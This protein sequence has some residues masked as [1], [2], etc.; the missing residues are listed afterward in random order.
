MLKVAIVG[1]GLMGRHHLKTA[2]RLGATV[3]GVVD[4]DLRAAT[5][6]TRGLA[7]AHA[8]ESLDW[9]IANHSFDV[10]HVCT[11]ASSH[12]EIG[13]VL[14]KA[15]IAAFVEKPLA[16]TADE[17]RT[18]VEAFSSSGAL[19]CPV[20]QYAFQPAVDKAL[21]II[22][23]I[24]PIKSLSFDIVS[25]GGINSNDL[26]RTAAEILPHPLAILQRLRPAIKLEKLSWSVSRSDPGEWVV[27]AV[28][29]DLQIIISISLAS[30][31][32][33]F[34]TRLRGTHGSIE[35]NN[36]H[37][38]AVFIPGTVSR[39]AKIRQPFLLAGKHLATASGNLLMRAATFESAYPGLRTLT[40]KFYSAVLSG[41]RRAAPISDSDIIGLA[42]ARDIIMAAD[43]VR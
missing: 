2:Q 5:D 7:G 14:A 42:I 8:T 43:R 36:F 1:A 33:N 4:H 28:H 37:G 27:M 26:D 13:L 38:Y 9:L 31:P 17:T 12:G 35:I 22:K 18:I 30:R 6:L 23:K 32:T 19:L 3:V 41:N 21:R 16:E 24:G 11:P 34:M 15:R 10:A 25:A 20:H 40:R 29:D 39:A